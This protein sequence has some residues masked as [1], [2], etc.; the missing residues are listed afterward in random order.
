MGEGT[1]LAGEGTG[2]MGEGT[3]LTGEG[4]GLTGEGTGLT[5]EGTGLMGEGTGLTGE[6]AGDA[7]LLGLTQMAEN[8]GWFCVAVIKIS[9]DPSVTCSRQ[10]PDMSM[11][12]CINAQMDSLL[13]H[14]AHPLY[15]GDMPGVQRWLRALAT[16]EWYVLKVQHVNSGVVGWVRHLQAV[17]VTCLSLS[18]GRTAGGDSQ[19]V[20]SG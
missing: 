5:G 1:G 10:Q 13:L 20:L 17:Q 18:P 19:L 2:L 3:G 15:F 9:S 16:C 6:G 12:L 11:R 7:L 4:T 8:R 14:K